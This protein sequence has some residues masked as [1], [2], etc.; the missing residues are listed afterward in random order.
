ML[1]GKCW[2]KKRQNEEHRQR[3][4][5]NQG[6]QTERFRQEDK[7]SV[8]YKIRWTRQRERTFWRNKQL[9]KTRERKHREESIQIFLIKEWAYIEN[10]TR[11]K[12]ASVLNSIETTYG[13]ISDWRKTKRH[14]AALYLASMISWYYFDRPEKLVLH[15]LCTEIEPPQNLR[16]LMALGLKFLPAPRFT[17]NNSTKTLKLFKR[18]LYIKTYP[19]IADGNDDCNPH[20]YAPSTWMPQWWQISN[21]TPRWIK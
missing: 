18:E 21:E 11:W 15:D 9:F 13:F 10:T 5:K 12:E 8:G 7:I 4:S 3:L 19:V 1:K 14:N 20:I 17:Y 6:S 2:G 16:S